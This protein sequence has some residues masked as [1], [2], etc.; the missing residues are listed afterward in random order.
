MPK[1]SR[2]HQVS[3]R[4]GTGGRGAKS[5]STGDL[6]PIQVVIHADPH[7]SAN[8]VAITTNKTW[9]NFAGGVVVPVPMHLLLHPKT[10]S[11]CVEDP[12]PDLE[13]LK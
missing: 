5:T 10:K 1:H 4:D 8:V 12:P 7:H 11:R 9:T 13:T 6:P 3:S 2:M